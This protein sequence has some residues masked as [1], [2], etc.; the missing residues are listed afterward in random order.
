MALGS[1]VVS[2]ATLAWTIYSDMSKKTSDPAPEV[3]ARTLRV[4][5]RRHTDRTP[6]SDKITEVVVAEIVNRAGN[7]PD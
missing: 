1:L 4:Q 6:D 7:A 2:I 3:V 5:L